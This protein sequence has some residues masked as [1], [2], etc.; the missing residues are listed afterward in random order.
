VSVRESEGIFI[1]WGLC[2]TYQSSWASP[3]IFVAKKDELR[4]CV[5]FRAV[6]ERIQRDA[7]SLP[8]I[9]RLLDQLHVAKFFAKFDLR[10]DFHQITI[11]ESDQHITAFTTVFGLFHYKVVPFGLSNAPVGCQRLMNKVLEPYVDKFC[12]VYMDDAIC[13]AR[14]KEEL[15]ENVRKILDRFAQFGLSSQAPQVCL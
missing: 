8:N 1:G 5:D 2:P 12:S 14:S 6:N 7:H 4:M 13:W 9:D 15:A 11:R 10:H 3:T